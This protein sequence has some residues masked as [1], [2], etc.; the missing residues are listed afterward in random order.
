MKFTSLVFIMPN[1]SLR[2]E[3]IF[4]RQNMTGSHCAGE[5]LGLSMM[6][7][8]SVRRS[9]GRGRTRL[10]GLFSRVNS[11]RIGQFRAAFILSDVSYTAIMPL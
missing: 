5:A 8:Q 9:A 7:Q 1:V 11:L 2:R 10:S 4:N 3:K 6:R